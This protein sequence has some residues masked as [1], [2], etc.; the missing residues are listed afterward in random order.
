MILELAIILSLLTLTKT[1]LEYFRM[2]ITLYFVLLFISLP[3]FK[4]YAKKI[5]FLLPVCKQKILVLGKESEVKIFKKE[6]QENWYLGQVY[7]EKNMK[8]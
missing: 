3:V 2:F 6:L 5:I 8:K 1:H 4:R 7:S